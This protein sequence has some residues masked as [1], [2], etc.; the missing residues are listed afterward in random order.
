MRHI[1]GL[2]PNELS[3]IRWEATIGEVAIQAGAIDDFLVDTAEETRF[4]G[5]SLEAWDNGNYILV[6][7]DAEGS[8]YYF[9]FNIERSGEFDTLADALVSAFRRNRRGVAIIPRWATKPRRLLRT[10]KLAFG[11]GT[12]SFWQSL[13]WHRVTEDILSRI[14]AHIV[15][16][17][18]GA[19]AGG[20]AGFLAGRASG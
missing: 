19:I 9:R 16:G 15:T 12:P 7:C 14:V 13:N 1:S 8:Y 17:V 11:S 10:S 4:D 20:T 3:N 2:I 5:L 18:T 6:A